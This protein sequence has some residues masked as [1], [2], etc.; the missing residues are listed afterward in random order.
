MLWARSA[1]EM[2]GK[3]AKAMEVKF[4]KKKVDEAKLAIRASHEKIEQVSIWTSSFLQCWLWFAFLF[5]GGSPYDSCFLLLVLLFPQHLELDFDS[6]KTAKK[7]SSTLSWAVS[8]WWD[9]LANDNWGI[10]QTSPKWGMPK[11][12][13]N[14]SKFLRCVRW[15]Q[16]IYFMVGEGMG[17]Q[18][19]GNCTSI[20]SCQDCNDRQHEA[21]EMEA[22]DLCFKEGHLGS[23][24]NDIERVCSVGGT[25]SVTFL[26]RRFSSLIHCPRWWVWPVSPNWWKWWRRKTR[27]NPRKRSSKKRNKNL[28]SPCQRLLNLSLRCYTIS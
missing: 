7:S 12:H 18:L 5:F 16:M 28:N 17:I 3:K 15:I 13:Q 4:L 6:A 27:R 9:G 25:A 8:R 11:I 2:V 20:R 22:S 14:S 21:A 1:K 23:W 26:S 19:F 24:T 10:G